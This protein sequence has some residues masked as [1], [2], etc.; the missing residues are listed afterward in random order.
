MSSHCEFRLYG[1]HY[2]IKTEELVEFL[3]HGVT[4]QGLRLHPQIRDHTQ[5]AQVWVA[6]EAE[7][8][9]CLGLKD[10]LATSGITISRAP[11]F[12]PTPLLTP[13][14]TSPPPLSMPATAPSRG[15][16]PALQNLG[17]RHLDPQGPLPRNLYIMGLPLDLTQ[18][19]FK[20]LFVQFGMV[21]HST[22][23]SQLDGFGRRRGFVLMST[24][25]EAVEAMNSLNGKYIGGRWIAKPS[26]SSTYPSTKKRRDR[27]MFRHSRQ[28]SELFVRLQVV[29][30]SP[31]DPNYF[32][33]AGV[34][35]EIFAHF[36]TVVRVTVLSSDSTLQVLVQ[37]QH[38]VSA[39][40]L[41]NANGLY[42]GGRVLVTRRPPPS[43]KLPPFPQ[44]L[45]FDPFAQDDLGQPNT[46]LS[47]SSQPFLPSK[48]D[49]NHHASTTSRSSPSPNNDERRSSSE[50]TRT[51]GSASSLP[52]T[53]KE[54]EGRW[55]AS[56]AW[57]WVSVPVGPCDQSI[58]LK[59]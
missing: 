15:M 39:I 31:Q 43:C 58:E 59:G 42:L 16:R 7:L 25:R 57:W 17:F 41:I 23:L 14:P 35:R 6:N 40:A 34:I 45:K 28:P 9:S 54:R 24:H 49:L 4:I 46:R 11:S 18:T 56:A 50:G 22:L 37:Y 21:E 33:N 2:N 51:E 52:N 19:Q 30:N 20:A 10:S 5:W 32:P 26:P 48:H 36:G 29:I 1:L 3:S 13:P 27:G 38:P 53:T 55:V 47:A 8:Q 44:A 12:T